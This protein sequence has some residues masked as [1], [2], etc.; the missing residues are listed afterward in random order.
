MSK[1]SVITFYG[2]LSGT[3]YP[4]NKKIFNGPPPASGQSAEQATAAQDTATAAQHQGP[5]THGGSRRTGS[6]HTYIRTSCGYFIQCPL[7]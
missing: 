6:G 2:F 4:N 1:E 5:T 7:C 3:T